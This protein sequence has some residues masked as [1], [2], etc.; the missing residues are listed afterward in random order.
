MHIITCAYMHICT[1]PCG[2]RA[3][4]LAKNGGGERGGDSPVS[5]RSNTHADGG[6]RPYGRAGAPPPRPPPEAGGPFG[7]GPKGPEGDRA[8]PTTLSPSMLNC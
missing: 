7:R 6:A 2:P 1:R 8:P 5:P 3:R 4:G